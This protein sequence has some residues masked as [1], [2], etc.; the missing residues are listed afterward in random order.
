MV[1]LATS[2]LHHLFLGS[3]SPTTGG[4]IFYLYDHAQI[5]PYFAE[6]YF[7]VIQESGSDSI[8]SPLDPPPGT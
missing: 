1:I 3:R 2:T 5:A 4:K 7:H 6:I 8:F